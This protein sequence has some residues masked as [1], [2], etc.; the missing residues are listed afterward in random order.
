MNASHSI[1]K[2]LFLVCALILAVVLGSMLATDQNTALAW[3]VGVA[4]FAVCVSMKQR[5]W[6]L[7]PFLGSMELTMRVP[8]LPNT[9][10]IAQLLV[11]PFLF[12]LFLM[13]K[14]PY[15]FVITELEFWGLVLLAFVV[16]VY[17]RN[18]VGLNLFG[19]ATVGGK[20][21][22]LAAI[23]FITGF[24]LCALLVH[25]RELQWFLRLSILGGILGT[26]IT[27]V[28]YFVPAIGYFTCLTS[29]VS[30]LDSAANQSFDLG[31]ASRIEVLAQFAKKSSLW[32]ASYISPLRALLHPL[33][34]LLL[35]VSLA[36]GALSGYRN[37]LVMVGMILAVGTAYRGGVTSIL[38]S[39]LLGILAVA[40]LAIGNTIVPLPANI[41]RTLTFLPGTWEERY[42]VDAKSSTDW[43]YEI[44]QEVLTSD[45]WIQN[46]WWGDGLGFSAENLQKNMSLKTKAKGISG[47]DEQREGIF[48]SGDYHS[49][50]VQTIRT[51]GYVGLFFLLVA[52]IRLAVHAHRQILRC[53]NTNW[54]PLALFIGIPLI[55]NPVFFTF[56]FGE[57]KTAIAALMI[58]CGMVRMLQN[59]LPLPAWTRPGRQ[60]YILRGKHALG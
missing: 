10:L 9:L 23:D 27:A 41:Q 1:A 34:L 11:F 47:F 15:K 51:I 44:W 50:P 25:P 2:I 5:I 43:R 31:E 12:L 59:N 48:I 58:G 32:V 16:Q 30:T 4:M 13:R 45:K 37:T 60:P 54:Y 57:F 18:P 6:L 7:I 33:W 26:L 49:G 39:M 40:I 38:A 35:L 17:I 22:L 36:S 53:R 19:G 52:Q 14:L 8:G 21:Y 42:R 3:V 29:G 46:K 24:I 56:V 20:P 55:I 28:G